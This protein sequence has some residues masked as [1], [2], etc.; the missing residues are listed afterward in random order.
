VAEGLK[1]S[2]NILVAKVA[3][4][5]G[6]DRLHRAMWNF[7]LG[8]KMGVDLPGEGSGYLRPAKD[9]AQI[10]VTRIAIGQGI[11]VTALQ[12]LGIFSAIANDGFLMRP[13]VVSC[14]LGPNGT[15]LAKAEPQVLGRPISRETAATMRRLLMRVT[16]DGGTGTRGRV[17][18]WTVAGKTGTSQKP[19]IGG[20]SDTR[21]WASFVGFAP[22]ERPELAAIV[23]VD[24]PQGREYFG[25][26]VAAPAFAKIM[27][28]AL[29]Y[30]DVPSDSHSVVACASR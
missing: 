30:L 5:L 1:K 2:S 18:G 14:V 12:M 4:A 10:S 19:E 7:G 27:E 24:E 28:Q 20:Y 15:I 6:R 11:S 26:Q 17:D 16:E 29:R 9:W 25:G 3:I 13:Y 21:H 8:H 22:V 23:V